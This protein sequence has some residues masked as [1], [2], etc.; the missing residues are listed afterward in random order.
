MQQEA[1]QLAQW[2]E[3]SGSV[4]EDGICFIGSSTWRFWGVDDL[5]SDMAPLPVYNMGFGGSRMEDV[6]AMADDL[7]L[8]W[9]PKLIVYYTGVNNINQGDK[10]DDVVAGFNEFVAKIRGASA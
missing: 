5:R 1:V 3:T 2:Q 10:P 8:R 6:L 4:P 9:K 7:V